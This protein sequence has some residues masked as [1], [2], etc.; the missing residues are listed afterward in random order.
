M[1]RG[2][3]SGPWP[4]RQHHRAL[5]GCQVRPDVAEASEVD[6]DERCHE[7]LGLPFQEH[8]NWGDSSVFS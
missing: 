6:G 5:T 3:P 7:R 4:D 1:L 2:W 8:P